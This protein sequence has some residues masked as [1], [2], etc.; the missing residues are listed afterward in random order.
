MRFELLLA[1][2]LG[3]Q[4]VP[5]GMENA[6]TTANVPEQF[7]E[8]IYFVGHVPQMALQA[9]TR[10]S[11]ALYIPESHYN[12][13]PATNP[14]GDKLPLLVYIHGTSRNTAAM[15]GDLV[16]FADSV[17]C[18]VIAP[19]F[20]AG[21]NGP[22]DLDS[23][24]ELKTDSL[25]SDLSLLNI[26]DEVAYRWPGLE[27]SKVF[28]MGFSGGGQFAHRFMYLYPERLNAISIGAPGRPTFLDETQDWPVGI[29]D[30][31][32]V[33][34]KT[35][36]TTAIAKLPIQLVVGGNDTEIH[37]SPEFWEWEKEVL[38]GGGLPPMNETRLE[39]IKEL[40]A[41]WEEVGIKTQFDIVLGVAHNETGVRKTV[42]GFLKP[43]IQKSG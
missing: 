8:D 17:P 23:F 26:L 12:A 40:R 29:A 37:G 24:K 43:Q 5:I 9:D 34:G 42:L 35:V 36:S 18:A 39:S 22:N 14:A 21:L 16:P 19:I 3:V 11:Y 38:G 10:I 7:L 6:L 33:F 28:M 31:D 32:K 15:F 13:N 20:P 30:V 4:A 41:S 1:S 2:L 27:T 25:R